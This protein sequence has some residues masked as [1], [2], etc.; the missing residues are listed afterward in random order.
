MTRRKKRQ[1]KSESDFHQQ[2]KAEKQYK[3]C[4]HKKQYNSD[5]EALAWGREA[6]E[7]YNQSKKWDTYFC[8]YCYHWHLTSI[9][10]QNEHRKNES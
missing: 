1:L 2:Y 4:G 9:G 3:M 10:E 5:L 8:P 7:R 6:N